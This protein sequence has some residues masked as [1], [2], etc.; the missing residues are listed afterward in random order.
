M[1]YATPEPILLITPESLLNIPMKQLQVMRFGYGLPLRLIYITSVVQDSI[2]C[3]ICPW[4]DEEEEE[5]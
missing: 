5:I 3:S 4:G 2:V 1:N